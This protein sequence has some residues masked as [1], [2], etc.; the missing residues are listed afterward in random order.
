[1]TT[2]H[3][4]EVNDMEQNEANHTSETPQALDWTAISFPG[5]EYCTLTA[6]NE[7]ALRATHYSEERPLSLISIDTYESVAEGLT[8]KFNEVK[9]KVDE[10]ESEWNTAEDVLKLAGKL[11]RLKEY[12]LHANAIGDYEPLLASIAAK[13]KMVKEQY[14][15]NL[16][17]KTAI[18]DRAIAIQDSDDWKAATDEFKNIIDDWKNAPLVEKEESDALWQKIEAARTKFYERKR[19]HQEDIEKEMMQNLDLKLE[20]CEQAEALKDSDDWRATSDKMKELMEKWKGIGRVVSNEKNEELWN[21]FAAARKDFFDRKKGHSEAIRQ[22]QEANYNLKLALVEKAEALQN[23]IEWKATSDAYSALMDEWK[24]IGKVPAEHSDEL[25]KRLQAARD[26]F[27][28][29]K[30]K[31]NEDFKIN[32]EDNYAQKLALANRAEQIKDSMDWRSATDE[33]NEL[34]AEWKNV[35]PVPREHSDELW[36]KFIA[37]RH[38]F[39]DRKDAD[40]DK[41]KA[42][43]EGHLSGRFKQ[44]KDFLHKIAAE[45][46]EEE[47]KLADFQ[48]SLANTT[49]EGSK[50]EELRKHLQNL[51][52]QIEKK[53][54]ARRDKIKDVQAQ[55]DELEKRIGELKNKKTEGE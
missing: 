24:K 55:Y 26:T 21:R 20:L 47:E 32:L 33:M 23:S 48:E 45:L 19:A 46:Q 53:L 17:L 29:A 27:F 7:I 31:H 41:R 52:Q 11:A 35:G 30:R 34:M 37:A 40:R 9:A 25:W 28:G 6:N 42:R 3:P 22:E 12:L 13:E 51:I 2:M 15:N 39:F 14:S 38:Y 44:T 54:P 4:N 18:A 43:A 8:S 10:L 36:N 1:M 50:E 49:G 16:K 5:K